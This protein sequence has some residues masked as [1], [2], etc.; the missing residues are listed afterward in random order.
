MAMRMSEAKR[1]F[2]ICIAEGFAV[3][4]ACSYQADTIGDGVDEGTE[5]DAIMKFIHNNMLNAERC[6][7]GS[8]RYWISR[9]LNPKTSTLN[10]KP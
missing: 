6:M 3:L 7:L 4:M 5:E 9:T 1:D 10:P 8:M 2:L